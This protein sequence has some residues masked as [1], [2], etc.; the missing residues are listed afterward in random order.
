MFASCQFATLPKTSSD[1]QKTKKVQRQGKTARFIFVQRMR[2]ASR[3]FFEVPVFKKDDAACF[4]N[5]TGLP[6]SSVSQSSSTTTAFLLGRQQDVNSPP[7]DFRPRIG[8]EIKALRQLLHG[9]IF[10]SSRSASLIPFDR[11]IL[12][13]FDLR[14]GVGSKAERV[15][16]IA[17]KDAG[18]AMRLK[19][20]DE[21]ARQK[22]LR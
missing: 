16:V 21:V 20:L 11:S 10:S 5:R 22:L 17:S 19:M 12:C 4:G 7:I 18:A 2:F 8:K 15:S 14:G 1:N 3:I 13:F 9:L 6:V